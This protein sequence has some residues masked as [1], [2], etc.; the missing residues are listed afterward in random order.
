MFFGLKDSPEA[1]G[2]P[3]VPTHALQG[4]R[5]RGDKG[6]ENIFFEVAKNFLDL[7][8]N[9]NLHIQELIDINL[10]HQFTHPRNSSMSSK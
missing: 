2:I 3:G 4:P 1:Y 10:K 5:R 6:E 9:I 8:K 7:V